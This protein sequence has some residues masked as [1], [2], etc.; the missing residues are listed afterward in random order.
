MDC[1]DTTLGKGMGWDRDRALHMAPSGEAGTTSGPKW[2]P[3]LVPGNW[4][5]QA[6]SFSLQGGEGQGGSVLMRISSPLFPSLFA[7]WEMLKTA[8]CC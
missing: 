6:P 2:K 5:F 4:P 7:L 8:E 3:F 1:K